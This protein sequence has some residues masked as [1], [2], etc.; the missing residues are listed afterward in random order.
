[1]DK[2]GLIIMIVAIVGYMTWM[3]LWVRDGRDYCLET[4]DEMPCLEGTARFDGTEGKCFCDTD[5]GEAA[6][7]QVVLSQSGCNRR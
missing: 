3:T 2:A 1:M 5:Y 6:W 4:E 7:G